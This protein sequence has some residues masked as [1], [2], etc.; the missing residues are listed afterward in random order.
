MKHQVRTTKSRRNPK[1]QNPNPKQTPSHKFQTKAPGEVHDHSRDLGF[2]IW[3]LFGIWNLEFGIS[4]DL[5][6]PPLA[7]AKPRA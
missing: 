4:L 1:H 5:S 2:G 3:D 7:Q 6:R